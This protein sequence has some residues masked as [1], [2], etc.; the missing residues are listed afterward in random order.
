MSD[1]MG[2]AGVL[3]FEKLSGCGCELEVVIGRLIQK[4]EV[5]NRKMGRKSGQWN[6]IVKWNWHQMA[7]LESLPVVKDLNEFRATNVAW[8][9][10]KTAAAGILTP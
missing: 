5:R 4:D 1:D 8:I 3:G 2:C 10:R 6:G 7:A 9:F